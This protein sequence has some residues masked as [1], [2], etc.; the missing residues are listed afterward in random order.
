MGPNVKFVSPICDPISERKNRGKFF[1]LGG[2]EGGLAK[3]HKKYG[4]FSSAPF[5]KSFEL[6]G[7]ILANEPG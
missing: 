5:P 1:Y 4:F 2:S 6:T 7:H 3:D